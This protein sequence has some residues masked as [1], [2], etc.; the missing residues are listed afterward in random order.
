MPRDSH[1]T[2]VRGAWGAA[3]GERVSMKV[4]KLW[5]A[6]TQLTYD[7]YSLPVCQPTNPERDSESIGQIL[8]GDRITSS[9]YVVRCSPRANT[10]LQR[11]CPAR[12]GGCVSCRAGQRQNRPRA[13]RVRHARCG[14]RLCGARIECAPAGCVQ[15]KVGE[16]TYCNVLCS[17]SVDQAGLDLLRDRI[18]NE[19][20][21][22]WIVD[23]L[24]AVVR[25]PNE[26]AEEGEEDEL[27]E[28]GFLIG[29]HDKEEANGKYMLFN[30]IRFVI[31]Y[32]S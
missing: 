29:Y 10:L 16:T 20:F 21:A 3:M 4:N 8:I 22:Q 23:D 9:D 12:R 30:H 25:V 14:A 28:R 15:L 18:D 5:S 19:Y 2:L 13:C 6:K 1:F 24:P 7:Y 11:C 26:E 17:R 31:N 32:N 27:V